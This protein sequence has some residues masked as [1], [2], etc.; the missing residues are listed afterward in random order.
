LVHNALPEVDPSTLDPSVDLLGRDLALPL[1][2]AGMTG[3]HEK[4]GEVNAVLA[5]AAQRHRIAMGVGSQRAALVDPRLA[6][7]YTIVRREAPDAFL[8]ANVGVAQLITRPDRAALAAEEIETLIGMIEAN[9]LAIHLNAV[10]ELV[11]PEGQPDARGWLRAIES[12]AARVSVPVIAKE[13]GSGLSGPVARRLVDAGVRA[14]DVGGSGGTSFAAIEAARAEERG[15]LRRAALGKTLARWGIPTA[16]SIT[17]AT[18]SGLPVIATGG[19]R[20]GMDGAKAVAMG[21]TAVVRAALSGDQAVDDW[22]ESFRS[23]LSAAMYLTGSPNISAL[24]ASPCII[25]GETADWIA[26]LG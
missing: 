5:R 11:Q 20:G 9:A 12:T 23:E 3:G 14:L 10:Q 16:V 15:D 7:S 2:I 25:L 6:D 19:V 18:R 4:G 17:V 1:V 26:A 24:H 13:T 22:V 21:A 8:I